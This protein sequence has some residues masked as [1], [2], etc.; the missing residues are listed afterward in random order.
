MP[1]RKVL[2]QPLVGHLL[3]S[4]TLPVDQ[5]VVELLLRFVIGRQ[6]WGT[7]CENDASHVERVLYL[8]PPKHHSVIST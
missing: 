4:T 2:A 1:S 7:G 5:S 6:S 8:R 3:C